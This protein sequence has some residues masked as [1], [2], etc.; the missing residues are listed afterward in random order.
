MDA[1]EALFYSVSPAGKHIGTQSLTRIANST[2]LILTC[3][4]CYSCI[5]FYHRVLSLKLAGDSQVCFQWEGGT[6]SLS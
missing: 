4:V 5:H 3:F 1:S 6:F 2:L